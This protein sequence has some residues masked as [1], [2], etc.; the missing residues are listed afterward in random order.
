[1]VLLTEQ[2]QIDVLRE[3]CD[4]A[5]K[6]IWIASPYIGGLKDVLKIIGGRWMLPSIDCRIL[7]DVDSGFIRKDT[8]DM[9]V[10]N[11]V[12]KHLDS[13]HAKIYIIDDW[14]LVTSANLTGTAFLCRYEMGIA[15]DDIKEVVGTYERWW[16]MAKDVL[17]LT[18]KPQKA[19]AEYQD[20]H[21]FKKKFKAQKY[22]SGMQD[23]YEA[24]CEEYIKFATLYEKITGRNIKMKNDGFTLLQ[25]VDYLFNFLYHDHPRKPSRNQK[26]RR[27]LT[28]EQR[29]KEIKKYFKEMSDRYEIDPQEWRNKRKRIIQKRLN[30][31]A[32]QN[33][34]WDEAK[35]V[36]NCLHCQTSVPIIKAKFLNKQNNNI[37]NIRDCWNL[38]LHTGDVDFS[39][40][41]NVIQRLHFFGYSSIYELIGWYKPDRYPLMNWISHCGMRF[42]GYPI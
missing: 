12:V 33:L 27:I 21:M 34:G 22:N 39:K 24:L 19:L 20:G 37:D 1:M 31:N 17:K 7:T 25:E 23:K 35:E 42:F 28:D 29:E 2:Q 8:F 4:S 32:I 38:L 3:K 13:L 15:T 6:R 9:F 18:K 11:G 41:T 26:K 14:C 10:D 40:V 30:P 5:K 16:K 36:V